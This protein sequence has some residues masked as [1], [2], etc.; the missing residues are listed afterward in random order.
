MD[1]KA[2]LSPSDTAKL[3]VRDLNFVRK[4]G[5]MPIVVATYVSMEEDSLD[6]AAVAKAM[7]LADGIPILTCG[8][9]DRESVEAVVKKALEL[10]APE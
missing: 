1:A 5:T 7:N 10:I 9:R 2:A 4:L 8:L 3:S 6:P